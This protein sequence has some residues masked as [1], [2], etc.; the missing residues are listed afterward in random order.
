MFKGKP[1]KVKITGDAKDEFEKL[2]KLVGEEIAKG[3]T[4]TDHQIL[5]N[6]IRTKIDFL[7]DN[8]QVGTHLAKNKIPKDYINRYD[9]NNIWKLNLSGAWRM[10]YTIR[11]SEVEIIALILDLLS[12]KDYE[13]KFGY[14]KS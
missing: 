13:K 14:K 10:I 8:P 11:G 3:V 4:G 6:S 7:K 5:F 9:V 12:H 1:I 2:N